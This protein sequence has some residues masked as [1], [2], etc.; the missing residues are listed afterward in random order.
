MTHQLSPT[1]DLASIAP[2][3]VLA[4][5]YAGPILAVEGNYISQKIGRKTTD[6]VWH[7]VSNLRGSV[8]KVGEM[9]EIAYSNGLGAVKENTHVHE[10]DGGGRGLGQ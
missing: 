9:A 7:D 8:P 4:G 1:Q 3:A 2:T 5:Q 6:I 10:L